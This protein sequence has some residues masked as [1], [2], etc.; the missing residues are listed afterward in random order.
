MK[1]SNILFISGL[2]GLVGILFGVWKKITHQE[3]ATLYLTIGYALFGVFYIITIWD[4]LSRPNM[5]RTS[6]L[7][8]LLLLF[9]FPLIGALI[10][11]SYKPKQSIVNNKQ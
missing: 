9:L 8:W 6:K 2:F 1:K 11:L 7:M 4:L 5:D 3:N 10:Y